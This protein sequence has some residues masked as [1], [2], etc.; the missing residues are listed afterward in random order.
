LFISFSFF[1]SLIFVALGILNDKNFNLHSPSEAWLWNL[2]GWLDNNVREAI[3]L[4]Q[5]SFLAFSFVLTF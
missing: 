2:P 3:E 4:M 1:I 5:S